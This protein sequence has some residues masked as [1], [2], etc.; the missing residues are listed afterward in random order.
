MET[1]TACDTQATCSLTCCHLDNGHSGDM[2]V[3][4]M[5]QNSHTS[6]ALSAPGVAQRPSPLPRPHSQRG[7]VGTRAQVPLALTCLPEG[8]HPAP[9][10]SPKLA[11]RTGR[12]KVTKTGKA[13]IKWMQH[14]SPL[15]VPR[16]GRNADPHARAVWGPAACQLGGAAHCTAYFST[17][18]SRQTP[19]PHNHL[20]QKGGPSGISDNTQPF[21]PGI[22]RTLAPTIPTPAKGSF[23]RRHQMLPAPQ[24]PSQGS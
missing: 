24:G 19:G 20:P 14:P 11:P 8:W 6:W 9:Q 21:M 13:E 10:E 23:Q 15:S 4:S 1:P 5:L 16:T 2:L 3:L 17:P 18:K 22:H 12:D 7:R